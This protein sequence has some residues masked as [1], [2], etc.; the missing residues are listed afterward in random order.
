MTVEAF[1]AAGTGLAVGLCFGVTFTVFAGEAT[2]CTLGFENCDGDCITT[3]CG[4]TPNWLVGVTE[5]E[6]VGEAFTAPFGG[7]VPDVGVFI[8]RLLPDPLGEKGGLTGVTGG[9]GGSSYFCNC[10]R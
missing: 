2:G 6:F 8:T 3:F 5:G 7:V 10:S 9:V 1:I 4:V